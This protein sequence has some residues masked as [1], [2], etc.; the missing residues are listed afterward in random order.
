[1]IAE[2][3]GSFR[4]MPVWVQIWVAVILVPANL[5]SLW[6]LTQPRGAWIAGMAIGAMALNGVLMLVE[7]GFSKAMALPHVL[8]WTPLV[9]LMA[10]M[11]SARPEISPTFVTYLQMLLAI[12]TF[13]LVLDYRDAWLWWRGQRQVAGRG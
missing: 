2:I 11:I 12:N 10:G 7:R 3:W 9:A 1:M 13:S 4:A 5:A 6:F 8:I